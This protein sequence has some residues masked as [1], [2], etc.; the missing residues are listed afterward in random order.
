MAVTTKTWQQLLDS[1]YNAMAISG[2][3]APAE[4]DDDRRMFDLMRMYVTHLENK[5]IYL[6]AHIGDTDLTPDKQSG[7]PDYQE[8]GFTWSLAAR[9]VAMFGMVVPNELRMA[10]YDAYRGMF[11]NT[12]PCK[13]QN[14]FQPTGQGDRGYD[15]RPNYMS[16]C[17]QSSEDSFHGN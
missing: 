1:T 13:T 17:E 2:V 8:H 4:D 16:G 14:P 9:A 3:T 5:G 11:C 10:A 7:I 15:V 12:A 6:G